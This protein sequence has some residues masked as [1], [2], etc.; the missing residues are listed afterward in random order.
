MT[1]TRDRKGATLKKAF[2]FLFCM[3]K[4]KVCHIITRLILGGAQQNTLI[5]VNGLNKKRYAVTLVGG[6]GRGPRTGIEQAVDKQVKLIVIPEMQRKVNPLQDILSFA[7]LYQLF[8]KE[9]YDIVHTHSTQAGIYARLAAKLAGTP[10]IIHS[11]HGLGFHTYLNPIARI[12]AWTGE[13][14]CSYFTDKFICVADAMI[15]QSLAGHVGRREQ[16][17]TI[18]SGFAVE[19]FL[20]AKPFPNFRKRYGIPKGD[21]LIAQIAGLVPLKGFEYYLYAAALVLEKEKQ[22]TF[23]VVG[24]GELKESLKQQ[25]RALGIERNVIFT[26][27]IQEAGIPA[28]MAST[29]I[30]V[31][32]S[33][34]EG[35]ARV[36]PQALAAGKP[37]ISF[38]L[39]GAPE[40][41]IPGKTGILVEPESREGLAKAMIQLIRNPAVRKRF[42]NKGRMLVQN[43]FRAERMVQ[44]IERVYENLLRQK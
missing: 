44:E 10:I 8:R 32:A 3:R 36:L 26:G 7:K 24:E 28:L 37:C 2:V 4:I 33:L 31:H 30:L 22:V 9:Q 43:A 20:Q 18:R 21:V 35:L 11:I 5:T 13:K 29:D 40:V 39:D 6:P 12:I 15:Q 17:I 41:V 19:Q 23:L 34:R 27:L 16:F 25:A 1:D 14:V 42:G 38:A